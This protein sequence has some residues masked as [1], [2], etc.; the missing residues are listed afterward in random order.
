MRVEPAE[1]ALLRNG[2]QIVCSHQRLNIFVIIDVDIMLSKEN[3]YLL[4]LLALMSLVYDALESP[5]FNKKL[6]DPIV[7]LFFRSRVS[8]S[9]S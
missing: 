4:N 8:T 6:V 3:K 5:K 2:H 9:R 7:F 1:G